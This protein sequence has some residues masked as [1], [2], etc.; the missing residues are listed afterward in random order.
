MVR[1]E[2]AVLGRLQRARVVPRARRGGR[3]RLSDPVPGRVGPRGASGRGGGRHDARLGPLRRDRRPRARVRAV[4]HRDVVLRAPRPLRGVRPRGARGATRP[5]D[6][7]HGPGAARGRGGSFAARGAAGD[8]G[9]ARGDGAPV[10]AT[11]APAPRAPHLRTAG[12]RGPGA[13]R[14]PDRERGPRGRAPAAAEPG[15]RAHRGRPRRRRGGPRPSPDAFARFL[16]HQGDTPAPESQPLPETEPAPE[17]AAWSIPG[18]GRRA[19]AAPHGRRARAATT[20]PRSR[21]RRR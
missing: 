15:I 9:R 5:G 3:S 1:E 8:R 4:R 10:Q 13:A 2:V 14:R 11:V 19:R 17:P 6:R 21:G 20:R 16:E 12:D 18:R 7:P